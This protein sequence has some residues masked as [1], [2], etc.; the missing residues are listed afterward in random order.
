MAEI[1]RP[2]T[3]RSFDY[4]QDSFAYVVLR[5]S[6]VGKFAQIPYMSHEHFDSKL[7]LTIMATL[8]SWQLY[9]T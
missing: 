2:P 4:V 6:G 8:L 1:C 9:F 3:L 5:T 7:A